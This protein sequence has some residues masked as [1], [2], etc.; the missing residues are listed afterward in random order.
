MELRE[1]GWIWKLTWPFAHNNATTFNGV[2]YYAKG[3]YPSYLRI[4]HEQ[5]HLD[6]EKQVGQ[7]KF[8]LLYL[9]ALP[10]LWNPWRYK[11]EW[12]AYYRG[13]R[14]KEEEIKK[15]LRSYKYGW[16]RNG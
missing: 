12:E 2:I 10:I 4:A 16:L 8:A 14:L 13:T 9:L 7:W 5:I 3:K 15:K 11:W 1:K 6:Q